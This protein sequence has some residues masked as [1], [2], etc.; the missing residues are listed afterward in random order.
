MRL[1]IIT[2]AIATIGC[3]QAA[4]LPTLEV[5]PDVVS[6]EA[7]QVCLQ[8]IIQPHYLKL[9]TRPICRIAVGQTATLKQVLSKTLRIPSFR[10]FSP[11]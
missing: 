8:Q 7:R 1:S 6:L 3:G 10:S 9:L 2:A 4:A 11:I 5:T